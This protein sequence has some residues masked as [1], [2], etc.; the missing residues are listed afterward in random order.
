M[1]SNKTLRVLLCAAIIIA[2]FLPWFSIMGSAA[3]GWN[4][5]MQS[6]SGE[7]NQT[8][9]T[10]IKYSFLLIPL[11]AL[12]VLIRSAA[13]RSSG[14]LLR[15]LPFLVTAILSA[16]FIFGAFDQGGTKETLNTWLQTLSTGYYITVV[17][18]FLL[19]L[20]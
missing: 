4:I 2:F 10:I 19:I 9:V 16:L 13:N 11:F 14:F 1:K 5:A 15:L 20:I 18:S 3:N 8:R 17:A 6:T 7:S 12:I